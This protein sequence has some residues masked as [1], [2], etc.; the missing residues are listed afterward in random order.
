MDPSWPLERR[1]Y[2]VK[3]A[4]CRVAIIQGL[5]KG[6]YDGWFDG[7]FMVVDDPM[8]DDLLQQAQSDEAVLG[9]QPT[10]SNPND[11]AYV[12]FTSG[13]TGKPKGVMVKHLGL[14]NYQ[15]SM[16]SLNLKDKGWRCALLFNY[17]FDAYYYGE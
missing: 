6:E 16:T 1:Q 13:S 8:W 10:F 15:W 5:F 17:Y 4:N 2:I 3:D 14:M 9:E 7:R 12:I 11:I